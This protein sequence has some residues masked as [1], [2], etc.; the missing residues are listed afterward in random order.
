LRNTIQRNRL[1]FA[2]ADLIPPCATVLAGTGNSETQQTGIGASY[3][4][5]CNN[6]WLKI[7][8]LILRAIT[9]PV[10]YLS[11]PFKYN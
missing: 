8:G 9:P 7:R 5:P 10:P 11:A 4:K 6:N 3:K 2:K 1:N